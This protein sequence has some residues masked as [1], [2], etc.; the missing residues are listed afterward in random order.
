MAA[1]LLGPTTPSALR[2][3]PRWKSVVACSVLGPK[4]AACMTSTAI[5]LGVVCVETRRPALA[6]HCADE[7]YGGPNRDLR[8][9]NH[10]CCASQGLPLAPQ[11]TLFAT[12]VFEV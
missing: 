9:A 4:V 12:H 1:R 6:V 3:C 11:S 8:E 7:P 2:P 10:L 5:L